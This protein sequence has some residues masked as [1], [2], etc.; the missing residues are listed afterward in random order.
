[1]TKAPQSPNVAKGASGLLN[2]KAHDTEQRSLPREPIRLH[3]HAIKR[4]WDQETGELVGWLYQWNTGELVP[5]WKDATPA[6][7]DPE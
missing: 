4:I 3:A 6:D 5:R 7:G 1:M 2:V